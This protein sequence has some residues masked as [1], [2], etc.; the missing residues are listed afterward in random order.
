MYILVSTSRRSC[1]LAVW[2]ANCCN[3][4]LILL[5]M[6]VESA[7]GNNSRCYCSLAIWVAKCGKM[8][9]VSQRMLKRS[10]RKDDSSS[11]QNTKASTRP[12][13]CS[14]QSA[15][16]FFRFLPPG[17][18]L[19]LEAMNV[20]PVN[21]KCARSVVDSAAGFP[22][23]QTQVAGFG[24][25]T[26]LWLKPCT[27]VSVMSAGVVAEAVG[28]VTVGVMTG[29]ARSVT[30]GTAVSV[31]VLVCWLTRNDVKDACV[32]RSA[33]EASWTTK[34]PNSLYRAG[35]F[36]QVLLVGI[37]AV[38]TGTG[39][40]SQGSLSKDGESEAMTCQKYHA[41]HFVIK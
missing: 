33:I 14:L 34:S 28:V 12:C 40:Q 37:V 7:F 25:A 10:A 17:L 32:K 2:V 9:P 16:G 41:W 35:H 30:G 36:L 27:T 22:D 23:R 15:Q 8:F 38:A 21:E 6:L 4:L 19:R 5:C 18:A 11:L 39:L 24:K 31:R 1:N 29:S 13:R 26:K 20:L 3:M